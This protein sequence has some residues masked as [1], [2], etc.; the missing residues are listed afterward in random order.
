MLGTVT[1]NLAD[2]ARRYR[3]GR[4]SRDAM[5]EFGCALHC[6]GG[7]GIMVTVFD[8]L[9][10]RHGWDAA[11]GINGAWQDVPGWSEI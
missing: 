3:D 4:V 11:H 8:A 1:S 2:L 10:D 9:V 7:P 6:I 5:E